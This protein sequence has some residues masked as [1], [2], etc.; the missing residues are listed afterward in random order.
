MND[1]CRFSDT[2]QETLV[3]LSRRSGCTGGRTGLTLDG[4]YPTPATTIPA[5][6]RVKVSGMTSTSPKLSVCP[7]S[8][9]PAPL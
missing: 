4:L 8:R 7:T 2:Y 5:P 3:S 6:W 9:I 1:L